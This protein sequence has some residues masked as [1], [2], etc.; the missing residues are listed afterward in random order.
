MQNTNVKTRTVQVPMISNCQGRSSSIKTAH[1]DS[2]K[3]KIRPKQSRPL[4]PRG[5]TSGSGLA[6]QA[7]DG[8]H[9]RAGHVISGSL[10]V[11]LTLRQITDSLEKTLMLGKIEGRKR[12][13]QRSRW[14]DGI[15]D[16]MDMSLSKLR[17]LV[18]DSE[19]LCA[20]VSGVTKSWT[21][22]S[23]WTELMHVYPSGAN[24]V[25]ALSFFPQCPACDQHLPFPC[26]LSWHLIASISDC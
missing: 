16:L 18:M 19:A 12:G 4:T 15:T 14:L 22:L 5:T 23:N 20:A 21:W 26:K 8:R 7:M 6:N 24:A 25:V 17:E 2:G 10:R 13:W 11:S 3:F 9:S 1:G